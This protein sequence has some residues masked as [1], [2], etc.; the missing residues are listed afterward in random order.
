[1]ETIFTKSPLQHASE[2]NWNISYFIQ[3]IISTWRGERF[4]SYTGHGYRWPK[5]IYSTINGIDDYT[6]AMYCHHDT[7]CSYYVYYGSSCYLGDCAQ[8]TQT[9]P[10]Q[11]H[12][13]VY[14]KYGKSEKFHFVFLKTHKI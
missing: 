11:G 1:M 13:T 9:L 2:K 3:G 5:F 6:C 7:Q 10:N 4:Y 8:T 12:G 14:Y